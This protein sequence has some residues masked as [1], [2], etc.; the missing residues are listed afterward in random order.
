M[1]NSKGGYL[2]VSLMNRLAARMNSWSFCRSFMSDHTSYL[3][4]IPI[5]DIGTSKYLKLSLA[6]IFALFLIAPA[7]ASTTNVS[8]LYGWN[9]TNFV[10]VQV[11]TGGA[12][13]TDINLSTST[14]LSPK[15]NN[16]YDL[17][18]TGFLWA[19]AYV[20]SI[21]GGSGPLSLFAGESE[22][23]T[24]LA[25]G[26]V[27]VRTSSPGAGLEVSGTSGSN[28]LSLNVNN[29]LYVNTSL[30]G[31]VG[32]GTTSP[33]AALD[34]AGNIT[35]HG[36]AGNA[37]NLTSLP[38]IN[39]SINYGYNGSNFVPLTTTGAGT[40]QLVVDEAV[41]SNASN[42][43]AGANGSS[44]FLTGN[45]TVLKNLSVGTTTL[46][47]DQ[48]A[49]RVGIGTATPTATLS[50]TGN[51][52][53]TQTLFVDGVNVTGRQTSDN[54][55]TFALLGQKL[56]LTRGAPRGLRCLTPGAAYR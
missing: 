47:V 49:T 15:L 4:F 38:Y 5:R 13:K 12:I 48:T 33:T 51:A 9:G 23:I 8:I 35:A 37:E 42:L 46:F 21:R 50:V 1:K 30:A 45:L 40:L 3:R 53:V 34:V 20:R 55:T 31:R 27:G 2:V 18:Q 52:T 32:V 36:F 39:I 28:N 25:G 44:L 24:L 6:V 14:G 56:N 22:R 10:P 29:T 11:T 19:N 41:S 54:T 7:S 17:G 26:N 43:V 16:T